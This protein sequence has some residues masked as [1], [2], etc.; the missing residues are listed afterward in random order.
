MVVGLGNPGPSYAATRHNIGFSVVRLLLARSG[1]VHL[2]PAF[3]GLVGSGTLGGSPVCFCLPMSYMNRSGSPVD[4][5]SQALGVDSQKVLV[6]HDDL[7]LPFGTV[8]C[9]AR[10][11]HGGHNGLKDIARRIG[12]DHPRVRFG[13]GRPPSGV[14]VA[15][16]VLGE[17][18]AEE[19]AELETRA[20]HAAAAVEGIL[21]HGLENA[22]NQF[23]VRSTKRD[24]HPPSETLKTFD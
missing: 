23:N 12:R 15:D 8:R 4:D 1:G 24:E 2:R 6:I 3:G 14:T 21:A 16:H 22:M 10:G 9:K 13:I 5:L 18:T 17:W 19:S 20:R 7:D 11:G